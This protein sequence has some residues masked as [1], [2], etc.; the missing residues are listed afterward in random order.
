MPVLSDARP[1]DAADGTA[2]GASSTPSAGASSRHLR[3]DGVPG[4]GTGNGREAPRRRISTVEELALID[5]TELAADPGHHTTRRSRR[6]RSTRT[7]AR[8]WRRAGMTE[9]VDFGE[10]RRLRAAD[11]NARVGG[12]R[13]RRRR[14]RRSSPTP[15]RRPDPR[16]VGATMIHPTREPVGGCHPRTVRPR[17]CGSRSATRRPQLELGA[18]RGHRAAG[19]VSATV[20][21]VSA[22]GRCASRSQPLP[23]PAARLPWSIRAVDVLDED[24]RL[25]ARELRIEL[26]APP[27]SR[28]R[29][30][31]S[32]S[33]R[34]GR[35]RLRPVLMV[36][37]AG[38]VTVDGD[39]EVAGSVSQGEI[40][41]DPDD[42]RFVALLA[43]LVA[44]R[45]VGAAATSA[46]HRS[47]GSEVTL[48]DTRSTRPDHARQ[49]RSSRSRRPDPVGRRVET[50]AEGASDFRLIGV[51][52]PVGG[53]GPGVI[54]TA[55]V[56]WDPPLSASSH[57][58][59]GGRRRGLRRPG[60]ACTRSAG[61]CAGSRL[62]GPAMQRP[63]FQDG[64]LLRTSDFVDEQAY[65]LAQHRRHNITGHVWGI[66]AGLDVVLL[67]GDRS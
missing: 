13:G 66:G 14:P 6:P 32:A 5:P 49:S 26:S 63:R 38:T 7:A 29:R 35:R 25:A 43:D 34:S 47:S 51:G 62:K 67:D 2:R 48:D 1:E 50:S 4:A 30:A 11:L 28:R 39:L 58:Q 21:D 23:T 27:G 15:A 65:H 52:G 36:D 57:G 61:D 41:P 20:V 3:C 37:A 31:A 44:R 45:V 40:P 19:S 46:G 56:P 60:R 17:A 55:P 24:D 8:A 22:R 42:P 53:R 9:H 16:L 54:T 10:G 18:E 64:R 12:A 33:A 59:A